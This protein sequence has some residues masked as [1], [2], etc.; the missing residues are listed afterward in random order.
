MPEEQST[1]APRERATSPIFDLVATEVSKRSGPANVLGF[2]DR[3]MSQEYLSPGDLPVRTSLASQAACS[4]LTDLASTLG[5]GHIANVMSRIDRM[6]TAHKEILPRKTAR[7]CFGRG[8]DLLYESFEDGP[9]RQAAAD[10]WA[11][12][13][14]DAA[15]AD[16]EAFSR[17]L[18]EFEDGP[19]PEHRTRVIDTTHRALT[20]VEP[21]ITA[22]WAEAL[23]A[24]GIDLRDYRV[25]QDDFDQLKS[26][27][28]D[29]FELAFHSLVFMA[30]VANI[31]HRGYAARHA[32]GYRASLR[33]AL[34][35]TRTLEREQWLIDFPAASQLYERLKRATRNDISHGRLRY[36]HKH[37][38]LVYGNGHRDSYLEFLIDYLHAVRLTHYLADVLMGLWRAASPPQPQLLQ[39]LYR[40]R[41][42][43]SAAN[44]AQATARVV[45]SQSP[46]SGL[47]SGSR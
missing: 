22:F 40:G 43:K 9:T 4:P 38:E 13:L 16:P 15:Q 26:R 6:R 36:D 39:D 21:L 30:R 11:T 29:I 2:V 7:A 25:Q 41:L 1:R 12:I 5:V 44:V 18:Y 3:R 8:L 24:R 17:L 34:E 45:E 32:N 19:L 31:A 33:Q 23:S 27:Y 20:S 46:Y 42:A 37:G 14:T 47:V 28:L 35:H 10:E